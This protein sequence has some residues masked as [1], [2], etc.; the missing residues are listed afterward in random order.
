MIYQTI[1][2]PQ[3]S[4]RSII[5]TERTGSSRRDRIKFT[6]DV[7]SL[8][9][10]GT[11]RRESLH[12]RP[13]VDS[14]QY[15]DEVE[16]R[17]KAEEAAL[18]EKGTGIGQ[19]KG[20]K[21]KV[22]KVETAGLED[23]ETLA[24]EEAE[25]EEDCDIGRVSRKSTQSPSA[26]LL[27]TDDE[28]TEESLAKRSSKASASRVTAKK[29][30]RIASKLA[31]DPNSDS[32]DDVPKTKVTSKPKPKVAK[33]N[34]QAVAEKLE[35]DTRTDAPARKRK[36]AKATLEVDTLAD[37]AVPSPKKATKSRKRKILEPETDADEEEAPVLKTKRSRTI[38][39]D[40]VAE[41]CKPTKPK[42]TPRTRTP[43]AT[44]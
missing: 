4:P 28:D 26:K 24:Q 43:K 6:P 37:D 36:T 21:V 38:N 31:L 14:K 41:D 23:D 7:L 19:T 35:K 44:P 13:R 20:K 16:E 17:I 2:L 34:V 12:S 1:P 5:R 25:E 33:K 39:A 11:R 9:V 22:G 8:S 27:T 10:G 15:A 29:K 18:K 30:N 32:E 3:P 40:D 42:S